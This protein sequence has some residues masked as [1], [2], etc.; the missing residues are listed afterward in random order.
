MKKLAAAVVVLTTLSLSSQAVA[1]DEPDSQFIVIDE[2]VISGDRI[3][4]DVEWSSADARARFEK[5]S[6]LKKSFLPKV[7][8][9]AHSGAL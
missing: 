2:L 1:Q 8:T 5:I 4:P 9:S 3:M 7:Q 6:E